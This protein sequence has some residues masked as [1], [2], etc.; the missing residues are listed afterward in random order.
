MKSLLVAAVS[1]VLVLEGQRTEEDE[2]ARQEVAAL[3]QAF[4]MAWEERDMDFIRE[5]FAHDPD[6]LLF[7][8]RRQLE[9]FDDVETL[10]ENMFAHARA[11]SVTSRVENLKVDARG[12][13]A[14][15]AANFHLDVTNPEGEKMTDT[16]RVT[17]VFERRDGRWRVVHR[18]TSFQA[19][20]GPQRQVP[21]VTHPGPLWSPTLEGA[22]RAPNG[23]MLLASPSFVVT[24]R[25]PGA[26]AAGR[27]RIAQEGLWITPEGDAAAAPRLFEMAALSS[28]E[29]VLR[30]PSG[31]ITFER[32]E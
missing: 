21:L 29:L 3:Y 12:D 23:E 28:T 10:Y 15:V 30:L 27:Y 14:Y 26:P 32:V 20:A 22:W 16:G 1:G 2:H 13:M 11:G 9:G 8:E 7:F 18:H 24:H 31:A 17:V 4:N 6:M 19:P 25:V 5:Y